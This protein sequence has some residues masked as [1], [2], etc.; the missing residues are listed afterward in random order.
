MMQLRPIGIL[1]W[2]NLEKNKLDSYQNDG[3]IRC[4]LEVDFDYPDK[5]HDL[6]NHYLL[7]KKSQKNWCLDIN[8]KF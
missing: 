3:P 7:K 8:F 4:A 1:D 6:H 2:A 5:S